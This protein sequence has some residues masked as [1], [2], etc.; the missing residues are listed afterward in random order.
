MKNKSN[1]KNKVIAAVPDA[2][3]YYEWIPVSDC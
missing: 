2:T 1:L 3:A